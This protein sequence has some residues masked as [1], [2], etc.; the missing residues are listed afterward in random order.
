M[1]IFAFDHAHFFHSMLIQICVSGGPS[2]AKLR[3][4]TLPIWNNTDCEEAYSSKVIDSNQLCAGLKAGGKDS[5]AGDSGGPLMALGPN[6]R[7]MIVGIVSWGIR[8]GEAGFPGVYT[9]VNNYL[10]WITANLK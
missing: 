2:S 7:W 10:D 3:E 6:R 5:C 9:R 4:V 1:V 8:C